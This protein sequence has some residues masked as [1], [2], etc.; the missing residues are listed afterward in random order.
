MTYPYDE[1]I[2]VFCY[3]S[4]SLAQ[5]IIGDF[6]EHYNATFSRFDLFRAR[7]GEFFS[8]NY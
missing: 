8:S 2:E 6:S 1:I 7:I 4:V 5:G 3:P